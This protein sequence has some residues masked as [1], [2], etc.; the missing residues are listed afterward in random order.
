ME[1]LLPF[2]QCHGHHHIKRYT[3]AIAAGNVTVIDS[4][5][6]LLSISK[7]LNVCP[8]RI[9][10]LVYHNLLLLQAP[11]LEVC[12]DERLGGCLY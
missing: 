8:P 1:V 3:I 11:W 7:C 5:K 12:S 2:V 4:Y 6:F 9:D 10:V